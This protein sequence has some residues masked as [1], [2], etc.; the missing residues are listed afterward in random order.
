VTIEAASDGEAIGKAKA[1]VR[2][3]MESRAYPEASD[4]D[5]RR[6]GVIAYIDRVASGRREP[7]GE[8]VGFDDERG[9]ASA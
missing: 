7:V 2:I 6:Q 5:K 8:D 3:V 4:T 1:A 9:A